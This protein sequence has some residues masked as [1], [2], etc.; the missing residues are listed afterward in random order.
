[1]VRLACLIGLCLSAC[2]CVACGPLASEDEGYGNYEF[3]TS[4][5]V[6]GF[7]IKQI[8]VGPD[9]RVWVADM[10]GQ[11]FVYSNSGDRIE[12]GADF[13]GRDYGSVEG[14]AVSN[15]G[16]S[17]ISAGST[18]HHFDA[19]GGGVSSWSCPSNVHHLD[20]TADGEV[21]A[22]VNLDIVRFNLDGEI[23]STVTPHF[24]ILKFMVVAGDGTFFAQDTE[25]GD[26]ET[27]VRFGA[28]GQT[29]GSWPL[30]SAGG[31]LDLGPEGRVFVGDQN[32]HKRQVG[33]YS[34]E[35]EFLEE[36]APEYAAAAYLTYITDVA[37]DE[38]TGDVYMSG[39]RDSNHIIVRMSSS[40]C[41]PRSD[42][43]RCCSRQFD[44]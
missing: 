21:L 32:G 10:D 41:D 17:F 2:W 42:T 11:V 38:G 16:Q 24:Y 18:I 26:V 8:A 37:V 33:I 15:D 44:I 40:A 4:W 25:E 36:I 29:L 34:Q 20:V 5:V 22:V 14:V 9:H 13:E 7:F 27:L 31:G 6:P 23:L 28:E 30:D 39:L 43:G 12:E 1:M 19:Q 35:G 3:A